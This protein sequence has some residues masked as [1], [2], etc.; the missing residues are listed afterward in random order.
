MDSYPAMLRHYM[1]AVGIRSQEALRQRLS[2]DHGVDIHPSTISCYLGGR[3]L[4]SPSVQEALLDL[5]E[6]HGEARLLA[7]RLASEQ[8]RAQ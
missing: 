5:L 8:A 1:D 2:I 4:P 3:R 6:I 7:Y